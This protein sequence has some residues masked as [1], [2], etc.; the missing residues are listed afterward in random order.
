[1]TTVRYCTRN[2]D[3]DGAGGQKVSTVR[4]DDMGEILEQIFIQPCNLHE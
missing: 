4:T 1:M 2:Q 3:T